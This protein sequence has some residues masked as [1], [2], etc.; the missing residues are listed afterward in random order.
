MQSKQVH[1]NRDDRLFQVVTRTFGEIQ[2]ALIR[3]R[4]SALAWLIEV[5]ALDIRLALRVDG[6]RLRRGIFHEKLG[7][8]SDEHE[9]H[10]AF[11]GSPNDI[12]ED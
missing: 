12:T 6:G 1:R 10:V 8:F 9:D 3:E 5:G 11:S 2:N 4:L 7:I